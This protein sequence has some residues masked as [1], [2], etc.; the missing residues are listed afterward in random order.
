MFLLS[1]D[2]VEETHPM[3]GNDSDYDPKKEAKKEVMMIIRMLIV[4]Q[5]HAKKNESYFMLRK[6][7]LCNGTEVVNFSVR[8]FWK[9]K[10]GII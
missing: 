8:G 1:D 2:D 4:L 5:I 7:F 10:K 9:K 3:D 6:T